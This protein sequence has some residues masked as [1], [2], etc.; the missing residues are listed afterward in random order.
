[1]SGK[2][3]YM[4]RHRRHPTLWFPPLSASY[5]VLQD[6]ITAFWFEEKELAMAFGVT[7]GFSR[8]GSILNFFVTHIIEQAYG[9][10]W[11]LWGGRFHHMSPH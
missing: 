1:M 6:R 10:Q 2:K 8:L 9:M 5:S 7:I 11:T 4:F 3:S